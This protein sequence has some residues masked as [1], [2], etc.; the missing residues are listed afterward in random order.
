MYPPPSSSSTVSNT[1]QVSFICFPQGI[2]PEIL[3]SKFV[4]IYGLSLTY[5]G[6]TCKFLTIQWCKS[7]TESVETVHQIWNL[8]IF[9]GWRYEVDTLPWRGGGSSESPLPVSPVITG[10]TTDPFTT[11]LCPYN[12]ASF[13]FQYSVQYITWDIQFLI[14][15]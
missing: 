13:H 12:H 8:D 9:P 11:I 5:D 7:A 14:I 10:S 6:L 1:R 15:K 2:F 3:E 4:I